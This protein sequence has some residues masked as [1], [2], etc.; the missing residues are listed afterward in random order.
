MQLR[1]TGLRGQLAE[2]VREFARRRVAYSLGR[3]ES[4]IA[5]VNIRFGDGGQSTDGLDYWCHMEA[6]LRPSG[7]VIA[8][9]RDLEL[10]SAITRAAERLSRSIREVL[11]R[12]RIQET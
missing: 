12:G 3:F 4:S 7:I 5:R 2:R 1:I 9:V 6:Q 11:E 8:E 10:E